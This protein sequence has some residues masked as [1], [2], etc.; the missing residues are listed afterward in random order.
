MK[1]FFSVMKLQWCD[2]IFARWK[3]MRQNAPNNVFVVHLKGRLTNLDI[4]PRKW[5]IANFHSLII[6]ERGTHNCSY[7][8]ENNKIEDCFPRTIHADLLPGF[9]SFFLTQLSFIILWLK[10]WADFWVISEFTGLQLDS[11]ALHRNKT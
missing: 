10:F 11:S 4:L 9:I 6:R 8:S 3:I 2:L 5:N 7:I 1:G